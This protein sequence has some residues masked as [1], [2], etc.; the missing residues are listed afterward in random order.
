MNE[1]LIKFKRHSSRASYHY[2][3]DSCKEWNLAKQ[4]KEAALKIFDE[5]QNLQNEMR[6]IAKDELWS[7]SKERPELEPK[8]YSQP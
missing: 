6:E 7:L 3:D 2:A 1:I 8:N 5:N 4:D